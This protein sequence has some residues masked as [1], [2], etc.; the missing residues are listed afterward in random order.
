[1][2]STHGKA[3]VCSF[4]HS[5]PHGYTWHLINLLV[6]GD[7]ICEPLVSGLV[8]LNLEHRR[9]QCEFGDSHKDEDE[10]VTGDFEELQSIW[11]WEKPAFLQ[12]PPSVWPVFQNN[13][14][15][16]QSL[17]HV[18]ALC[19]I[20]IQPVGQPAQCPVYCWEGRWEEVQPGPPEPGVLDSDSGPSFWAKLSKWGQQLCCISGPRKPK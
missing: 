16:Q 10:F 18:R 20:Q 4:T 19:V 6:S 13:T 7:W 5:S 15:V 17:F 9:Q 2:S 8:R 1:M 11:Q 12:F 14:Q 3:T